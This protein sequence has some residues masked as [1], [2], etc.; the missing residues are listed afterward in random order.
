MVSS[1]AHGPLT[2]RMGEKKTEETWQYNLMTGPVKNYFENGKVESLA[3][4]RSNR[5][6][7][8]FTSY[9]PNGKIREQGEYVA[10]KR[11]KEWREYS[12]VVF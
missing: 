7:G 10:G 5:L 1:R 12:E 8:L 4:Y 3:E 2:M 9:Y 11:H 6:H